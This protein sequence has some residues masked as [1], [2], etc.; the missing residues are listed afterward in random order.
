MGYVVGD[1]ED[2]P[3]RRAELAGFLAVMAKSGVHPYMCPVADAEPELWKKRFRTWWDDNPFCLDGSPRGLTLRSG[4]GELVGF[5]G[6]IP[7]DFVSG[8]RRTSGLIATTLVVDP[9]HRASST[10]LMLRFF[11]MGRNH[12]I[13]DSTATEQLSEIMGRFG[14]TLVDRQYGAY[15]PLWRQLVPGLGRTAPSEL[16]GEAGRF[17]S[18]S[19]EVRQVATPSDPALIQ[20]VTPESIRW[21]LGSDGEIR[22]FRGW[23]D[24]SGQLQAWVFVRE[25]RH[26]RQ[27]SWSIVGYGGADK[28]SAQQLIRALCRFPQA[29]GIPR[30]VRLLVSYAFDPSELPLRVKIRRELPARFCHILPKGLESTPKR[31]LQMDGDLGWV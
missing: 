27:K 11:R 28:V 17:V 29:A 10:G 22:H 8:E 16:G 21:F 30:D 7:Q 3:E 19:D 5:Q 26:A 4:T 1:F 25:T 14:A 15:L 13:V 6:M 12:H 2:S 20:A 24:D 23:L 9:A 18:N 31:C